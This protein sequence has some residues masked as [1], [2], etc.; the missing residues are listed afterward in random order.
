MATIGGNLATA[1]ACLVWTGIL[2]LIGV[3]MLRY[4]KAHPKKW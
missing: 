4:D 2:D 1:F 3:A